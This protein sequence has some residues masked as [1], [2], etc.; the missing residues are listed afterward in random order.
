MTYELESLAN[1]HCTVGE[2][3]YWDADRHCVYWTDIP[4]GKLFRYDVKTGAHEQFYNGDIVSGFCLQTGGTLLLFGGQKFSRLSF[5][6]QVEVLHD[7]IDPRIIGFNDIIVTPNGT[8]FAGTYSDDGKSAGIYHIALDGTPNCVFRGT[9]QSNGMAFSP[10]RST[11]YWTDS[12]GQCIYAFDYEV[13]TDALSNRRVF[14]SVPKE[15]G[16]P[17]GM[18]VD[19]DGN[20]WSAR[21]DGSMIREYSPVGEEIDRIVFP[22]PQVSSCLFGGTNYDELYVT[23][24]GG[25]EDSN[26]AKGTLFRIKMPVR[27]LPEFQS[28][29]LV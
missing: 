20:I 11:F 24:A 9:G 1:Y 26:T 5:D 18:T 4:Q 23:T 15:D 7:N 2:N 21:W 10:D 25:S 12:D 6:G 3:P 17:D 14:V 13:A 27:G 16:I 22:V 8:V 28:K 19:A 29:V